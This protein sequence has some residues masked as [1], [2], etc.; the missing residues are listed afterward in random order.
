VAHPAF[1]SWTPP[2]GSDDSQFDLEKAK[3]LIWNLQGDKDRLSTTNAEV[4][5]KVT[6]LEAEVEKYETANLSEIDR[7]KRENEKLKAPAKTPAASADDLRADR[8]EIALDKGLT[9][10]AAMRLVGTTREELEADADAYIEEHGLKGKTGGKSQDDKPPSSK[11]TSN[12]K[13]GTERDGD[14]D[15]EDLSNPLALLRQARGIT[16]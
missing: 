4:T 13:A 12:L 7:L 1:D 9:R 3:R 11:V 8:L 15:E 10:T 16:D 5:S 2:W 6:E 14:E